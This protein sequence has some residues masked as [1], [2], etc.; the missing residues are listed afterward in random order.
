M[1]V[2][3]MQRGNL[4]QQNIKFG[5]ANLRISLL[6]HQEEKYQFNDLNTR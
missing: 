4:L 5:E 3:P 2:A 6:P 1:G